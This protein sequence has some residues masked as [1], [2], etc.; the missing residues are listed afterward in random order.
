MCLSTARNVAKNAGVTLFGNL[1]F[2]L[3][4]VVVVI[5]MARYLGVEDFGKYNLVF[6]YLTF[7]SM[8]TDMGIADI[9]VREMARYPEKTSKMMSNVSLIKLILIV[10]AIALSIGVASLLHYPPDTTMYI[11][12]A[13]FMLLF[14]AYND[15][16]RALFQCKLKMEYE[17]I[18]K[19]FSRFLSAILIIYIIYMKGTLFQ[20]ILITVLSE[21]VKLIMN[22]SWSKKIFEP[23]FEMDRTFWK[24][25]CKESLP[26]AFSGIFTLMYHRIDVLMLSIMVNESAVGLYSAAYKLSEPL[27]MFP[28]A[29]IFSLYP[30]I[31]TSFHKSSGDF[32]KIFSRGIRYLV[33]LTLPVCFGV[34]ILADQIIYLVYD[35]SYSGSIAALRI[36][37]WSLFFVSL[38]YFLSSTLTAINKQKLNT[39]SVISCVFVNILLNWLMIPSMSYN[40]ASLATVITE[41]VFLLI[42]TYFIAQNVAIPYISD[43]I[44]KVLIS[45]IIMA[46]SIYVLSNSIG[47]NLLSDIV[48]GAAIYI[49]TLFILGT[50]TENEKQALSVFIKDSYNKCLKF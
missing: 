29:I 8:I 40:G 32:T 9:L 48:A 10:T 37:I 18:S 4:S 21:L 22:H 41:I 19:L 50:F 35:E 20:I 16:Y 25:M 27:E 13:S 34:T 46:I 6:A 3:I 28:Q 44:I 23:K 24:Y 12:V 43:V 30:L 14:Q 2:R 45:C 36:L 49:V 38:N 1:I 26:I 47:L 5:Y 39:Y 7:F 15:M 42:S 31:S 33:I 11:Y 17:I